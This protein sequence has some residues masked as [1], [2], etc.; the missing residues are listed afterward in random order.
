MFRIIATVAQEK[1]E[2]DNLIV[3]ITENS[4]ILIF[5]PFVQMLKLLLASFRPRCSRL[6]SYRHW[7]S[8]RQNPRQ[9]IALFSG[10]NRV[11]GFRRPLGPF[12]K[13]GTGTTVSIHNDGSDKT[14]QIS[15]CRGSTEIGL[16]QPS[17]LLINFHQNTNRVL[18][19]VR[20][21]SKP[22]VKRRFHTEL[23][24]EINVR[25]TLYETIERRMLLSPYTR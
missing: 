2:N 8:G 3:K 19:E 13:T 22:K 9:F 1:Q 10:P 20:K 15:R 12:W 25:R 18:V 16:Q 7:H 11:S 24:Y 14:G 21:F 17:N 23:G 6:S 4:E 5:S